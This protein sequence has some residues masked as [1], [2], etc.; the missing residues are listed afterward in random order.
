MLREHRNDHTALAGHRQPC[1]LGSRFGNSTALYFNV[2][3]SLRPGWVAWS[4]RRILLSALAK[5]CHASYSCLA[6]FC[7]ILCLFSLLYSCL[8]C[9]IRLCRDSQRQLTIPVIL[10]QGSS[11]CL[12]HS[13]RIQTGAAGKSTIMHTNA[14]LALACPARRRNEEYSYS[15]KP[16][17]CLGGYYIRE[18]KSWALHPFGIGN[19][20]LLLS[21]LSSFGC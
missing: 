19:L 16:A 5:W 8:H 21:P 9:V 7:F 1:D 2:T 15:S 6:S 11:A 17:R 20:S 13:I 14:V 10:G 4:L 3:L 12:L 18:T